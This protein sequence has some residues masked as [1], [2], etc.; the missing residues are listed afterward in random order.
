MKRE[1]KLRGYLRGM[2]ALSML[3]LW[4]VTMLALT[5]LSAQKVEIEAGMLQ[6]RME[7]QASELCASVMERTAAAENQAAMLSF[8]LSTITPMYA[9]VAGG[10]LLCSL[11]KAGKELARSHIAYGYAGVDDRAGGINNYLFLDEA[12]DDEG[13]LALA[14]WITEHR[15]EADEY[16]MPSGNDNWAEITGVVDGIGIRVQRIVLHLGGEV[17]TPVEGSAERLAGEQLET[18]R[19]S[20]LGLYS[21]LCPEL[22]VDG[23]GRVR[24]KPTI[25]TAR[26]A[27]FRDAEAA[28]DTL[29]ERARPGDGTSTWSTTVVGTA[30][31]GPGRREG[32]VLGS[33]YSCS[34]WLEG[35]SRLGWAYVLT[36]AA[37]LLLTRWL[38]RMLSGM[39]ARPVEALCADVEAGRPCETAG[40]I[41][42]LN[43]LS[44]AFNA[45]QEKL[46]DELR[47]ERDFSRAAAHEL[48]TPLAVLRSHAEGLAEDIAPDRRG[49]Y[50]EIIMDEADRMDALVRELLE[51]S[52][53]E[54]GAAP[55][56]RE[57]VALGALVRQAFARLE[58]PMAEKGVTLE[59]D[60]EEL[61]V[62]G[63]RVGLER[64]ASNLA[65][66][67]L[68]HCAPGGSIRVALERTG[69]GFARL[70]VDNDG[71]NIPE[72]ALPRLWEAFYR[73]DAGRSREDGG[74]GLGLAIVRGVLARHGGRWGA[75]NRPGGVRFRAEV[76][77]E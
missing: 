72:Q 5:F 7:V 41:A 54:A 2:I 46:A 52:R 45:A 70:T 43:A 37:A 56:A 73:G 67:A 65:S 76:P 55:L 12:L 68:R 25:M 40:E 42:E 28:Y 14:R 77:L 16:R 47:R 20:S 13:Q 63:E 26:L 18:L 58:R 1:T 75:E 10:A 35:A 51:L 17:L 29:M 6:E 23:D 50:L 61:T 57:P 38:S 4:A 32:V 33:A 21:N 3:A 8:G 64:V 44:S 15:D 74:A 49:E 11:D 30:A 34:N 60:L 39:V 19:F 48:K 27:R 36:L 62:P 22:S 24:N 59:A 9:Q 71:A 69:D 31:V 53:L 66:N